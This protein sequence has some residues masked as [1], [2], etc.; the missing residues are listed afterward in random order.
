MHLRTLH[1]YSLEALPEERE[2]SSENQAKNSLTLYGVR[3]FGSQHLGFHREH[4]ILNSRLFINSTSVNRYKDFTIR[5]LSKTKRRAFLLLTLSFPI[6]LFVLAEFT[7][8]L[9]RY[10]SDLSLFTT[11]TING[12]Q[13]F[14][15]NPEVKKRYFARVDFT[16]NISL[17][18]FQMPKPGSTF[19]IFCL[20][21]S[22]TAGFPY[23]FVGSFSTFLRDRLK[24]MFPEW[25]IEVVNLGMTATNSFTVLDMAREVMDFQPDLLIVYDGHNE[26]YGALGV[27]SRESVLGS[28]WLTKLYLRLVHFRTFQLL[29]DVY[30]SIT[31]LLASRDESASAGTMMERLARGQYIPYGSELYWKGYEIYK[32]NL[33]ELA[34]LCR[35]HRVPLFLGAQVSNLRDQPPFVSTPEGATLHGEFQRHYAQGKQLLA[36]VRF[37]EA[38]AEFEAALRFDSLH[39]DANFSLAR[40]LD[41]LGRKQEALRHYIKARDYDMLRFRASSDFNE[42]LRRM[43]DDRLI[44]FVDIERKFKANAPDSLVGNGLILEHLH[45]NARGYFLIA[46]EYAWK[47]HWRKLIVHTDDEWNR[48]DNLDDERMWN[49]RAMTE[50]DE[51]CA[52][53]RI[54]LLT[55]DWPFRSDPLAVPDVDPKDT[56]GV[57][58]EQ[59][60]RGLIT[61]EQGHVTAAEHYARRKDYVSVEREYKALINQIPYNVSAYLLLGQ[62]YLY[63]NKN[64]EAASILVR[65][66][67]VQETYFAYRTLG[68]LALDAQV[69]IGFFEKAAR[70]AGSQQERIESGFLLAQAYLRDGKKEQAIDQLEA[71]LY[72][73][74]DFAEARRLLDRLQSARQ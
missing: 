64:M 2:F 71:V 9:A 73:K 31:A 30:L 41:T 28:R 65:S 72:L 53:R 62:V 10:G 54:Q 52:H 49:E 16:P 3:C 4:S 48:R 68:M 37:E 56:I 60:V 67:E 43:D 47:M 7:L 59:M 18:H 6:I 45:P 12:A 5:E 25:R 38:R 42:L 23:S 13:Y 32:A 15:V 69:A 35:R 17:D 57:I 58:A 34:D 22:T 21:G 66:L 27:A 55:S 63:Q 74:P 29:R 24:A 40:C 11:E 8:R 26:F 1:S 20:G 51:R 70:L 33:E 44:T 61:W 46:K 39:A 50:L 19:R 14:F 36:N